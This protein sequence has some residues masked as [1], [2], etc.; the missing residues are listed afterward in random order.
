MSQTG[1]TKILHATEIAPLVQAL[2]AIVPSIRSEAVPS[3]AEMITSNPDH[4]PY[5]KSFDEAI[6]DPVCVLH[7]SGSTGKN[8]NTCFTNVITNMARLR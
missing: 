3:F 5:E 1:S 6:N 7:S 4:Y 2:Q 8:Y